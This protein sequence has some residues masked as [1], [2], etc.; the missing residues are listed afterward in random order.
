MPKKKTL[1]QLFIEETFYAMLEASFEKPEYAPTAP[2][3]A[4]LIA[5]ILAES[6]PD[7]A[8]LIPDAEETIAEA[9]LPDCEEFLNGRIHAN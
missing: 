1:N 8:A 9:F 6:A 3:L 5:V 2:K 4:A 7:V